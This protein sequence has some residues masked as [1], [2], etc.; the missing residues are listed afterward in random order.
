MCGVSNLVADRVQR[1]RCGAKVPL[2][3]VFVEER[4]E[5]VSQPIAQIGLVLGKEVRMA[6]KQGQCLIGRIFQEDVA[7]GIEE[8]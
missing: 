1:A 3:D 5:L 4:E 8:A 7:E 2:S 6:R